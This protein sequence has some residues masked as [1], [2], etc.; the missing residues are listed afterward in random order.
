MKHVRKGTYNKLKTPRRTMRSASGLRAKLQSWRELSLSKKITIL[1]IPAFIAVLV[2]PLL[3]YLWFARDV[4][5]P[6]RLMNRG[7]T[8]VR[9]L[10]QNGEEFFT[11]DQKGDLKRLKLE[12]ISDDVEKA[13]IASEDKDFYEHPG[14]SVSGF[15]RAIYTN[16]FARD[17]SSGG[18][19][20]TQQLVKNTL[21]S[22]E[23]TIF[24]KYQELVM[25]LAVER[26][27]E[28][29]E[30]LDMYLN[31]VYY[32]EGAF[33][34][35]EAARTYFGKSA[36]ELSL[37]ESS[38]LVGIMPAPSAYS[39]ISGDSIKAK[40]RQDYVLT[41]MVEDKVITTEQKNTA[42]DEVLIYAQP[43]AEERTL[44]PHFVEMVLGELYEK[45]GEEK[46]K[47][48][49]YVVKTTLDIEWQK[50]AEQIV[51]DQ[52]SINATS[53]GRN[54]S[55][56]AID[57]KTGAVRALVGSVDYYNAE[58]GK[59]NMAT[60]ARQPGSSFKPIYFTEAIDQKLITAS[61][62]IRD[63]AT[64]F[65]GYKPSN[66]DFRFR[67]DITLRNAL[68]QSLNIPAVKIMQELGIDEAVAHAREMGLD[69][70]DSENDY[71]LSLAL[72]SA[73]VTVADMT[74]AYGA[75]ANNG[76]LAEQNIIESIQTK[77]KETIY[78]HRT[79]LSN[80]QSSN[81]S[82]IIS[83]ILSD[84][85][86][87]SPS[88]GSRL[89]IYDRKVAVK[90][91]STDD[92]HDAWTIGYTPS[93]AVGV[94]VGNNEN[95]AMTSG[96]SMM[97][98]PIWRKAMINFLGDSSSEEFDQPGGV[99]KATACTA[100]KVGYEEYFI[101]GTEPKE[102]CQQETEPAQQQTDFTVDS[103]N[104][105]IPDYRDNCDNT[106]AGVQVDNSGCPT[107]N[108]DDESD[109]DNDGIIDA[110]DRCPSTP[111]GV[112][113]DENG[114]PTVVVDADGDGV[115]DSLDRCLS[116]PVGEQVDAN[117][118]SKSQQTEPP[119]GI[120]EPQT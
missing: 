85:I 3:T 32:G 114:C 68:A 50:S 47:R 63:E 34:I 61:T 23:Q 11:T 111:R 94:W 51:T 87:R 24:R 14:V 53:G 25:A 15:L 118:C 28:K 108:S 80:V 96:G 29:P 109:S 116:T 113:V 41:R 107:Q 103:D 18:S 42:Y 44:A 120:I 45:Y 4:S 60:T 101:K 62:I 119:P 75:F 95:V 110:D 64:D 52:T 88:F 16:I 91:G 77:Y 57:P 22:H 46:V 97:A 90:T 65:E 19:T 92:N 8:G 104:D 70:I 5:N 78:T 86:A 20:I 74:S 21:L 48:S 112:I 82:F 17:N 26:T 30:I 55:L 106:A 27:Y 105:G 83:D 58:F 54:A 89:N 72:G 10:D 98:G 76:R 115:V 66:Y 56:V 59:V 40:Q 81:A 84:N 79:K 100:T 36:V 73:E 7:N 35:D 117:G 69:T 37:A 39:P 67:G 2:I 33:G 38:M 71:G 31:S 6:E 102:N 99:I 93:L 13:V 49:G 12:E 1:G 9:L 43:K